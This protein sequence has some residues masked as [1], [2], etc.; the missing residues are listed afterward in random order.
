MDELSGLMVADAEQLIA[1]SDV[2]VVSHATEEFRH[3]VQARNKRVHILDLARLF[4]K[5][6]DDATYQGIAW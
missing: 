1:N 6:P 5:V 3:A 2:V 4:A